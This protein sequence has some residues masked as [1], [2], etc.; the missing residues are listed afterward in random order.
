[1][2]GVL[3]NPQESKA[4]L[5]SSHG[6]AVLNVEYFGFADYEWHI[7][8]EKFESALRYLQR[9][10]SVDSTSGIAIVGQ[11]K[12]AQIGLCMAG[13]MSGICGVVAINGPPM[14]AHNSHQYGEKVWPSPETS[15]MEITQS[16]DAG[17][18]YKFPIHYDDDTGPSDCPVFPFYNRHDVSVMYVAGLN[19]G[20]VPAEHFANC[21]EKLLSFARHP[22][23][24]VER[25]PGSGHLLLPPYTP[26]CVRSTLSIFDEMLEYGGMK[27]PHCRAQIDC[28]EK[29]IAFL[30]RVTNSSNTFRGKL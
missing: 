12:G 7:R 18:R 6:F 24:T 19:D 14:P 26:F 3:G 29:T 21:T 23:Y 20:N 30:R 25:Y 22:D 13:C 9:H 28:W 15:E 2:L 27:I 11:C 8:M 5:L 1:M 10:R 17:S 4:S 16:I